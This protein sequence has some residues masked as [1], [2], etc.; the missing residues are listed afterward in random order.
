MESNWYL[1]RHLK[2]NGEVFYIGIG[3]TKSFGRAH[4]KNKRTSFWHNIVEKYGYEIQILKNNMTKEEAAENE[5][6]LID[7]YGRRSLGTGTLVNLTNGGEGT[8][9]FKFTEENRKNLS[10]AC[11]GRKASEE[12]K[13]LLSSQRQG[14][15]NPMYGRKVPQKQKDAQSSK[16]MGRKAS[17]ETKELLSK[18]R[19]GSNNSKAKLVLCLDTGIFYDCALDAAEAYTYNS[20]TLQS[21]LR[22]A[23]PNKTSLIYV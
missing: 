1:Y 16:M 11:K 8:V 17:E 4:T 6:L 21:W 10:E 20:G 3:S 22:G 7:Y 15:D 14:S 2:P 23:R 19:R 5:I 18:Q 12:T 9:G 13:K